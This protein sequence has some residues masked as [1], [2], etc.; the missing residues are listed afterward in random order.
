LSSILD[1]KQLRVHHDIETNT[2]HT[3]RVFA[4]NF[5]S[6]QQARKFRDDLR[7]KGLVDCF[8]VDFSKFKFR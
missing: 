4:G 6:A 1:K 2:T 5:A 8:V 7:N 3:Y